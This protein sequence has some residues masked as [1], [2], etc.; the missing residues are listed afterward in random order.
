MLYTSLI[1]ESEKYGQS[2][3]LVLDDVLQ[4]VDS[5]IRLN[6]IDYLLTNFKDWQIIISA[7]DRLWLNQLRSA[8]RRHQHKFKEIE[9]FKWDFELGPQIIE[10]QLSGF[11]SALSVAI[12]SKNVQL[13]AS[14]TG[15]LFE[16]ICQNL[17]V[18]LNTSIQRKQGD[19]YTIG[20]LWPGIKKHFKKTSLADLTI[21]I[22]KVLHIRN[23][24]GAH[25]NEWAVS[26]SNSEIINFAE[27]VNNFLFHVYCDNCQNWIKKSNMCN[28][29]KIK[30][31]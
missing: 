8:F 13:I 19:R 10:P 15:L 18:T 17:S 2:K 4:S 23:L 1:Q 14:Q 29:N 26:L 21:E 7:H 24:F 16:S 27:S 28:C 5:V 25:Y 30:L 6:F 11:N 22:D 3:I 31:E 9:I 20:D 12:E